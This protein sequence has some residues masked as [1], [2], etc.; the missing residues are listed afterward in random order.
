MGRKSGAAG[1][2][3]LFASTPVSKAVWTMAL[4]TI[5]TQLINIIYNYA[6]TWYVGRTANAAM[7]AALGIC[8]PLF[9][10][11]AAVANL[12]GVGGSSVISRAMGQNN[13]AKARRT[14]ADAFWGGMAAAVVFM[15]VIILFR[16]PIIYLVGGDDADFQY[17]AD[18][19][20]WTMIIGAIPTIGNVLC[21]HLVRAIGASKEAGFGMS[22]GGILNIVLDPLFMF[23]ILPAGMEVTGAAIATLLSNTSAL[24][25]FLIYIRRRQKKEP[26]GIINVRLT[27]AAG[28]SKA[29]D[30]GAVLPEILLTGFPAALQTTFAM[31]S[32]IFAN[33]YIRPYGSGAVAGMGIAKKINMIAFNTCMGMTMGVLPL[34]GFNYGAKNYDRMRKVIRYTGTVVLLFGAACAVVFIT[35][36]PHLVRFFI[37][38]EE[39]VEYGTQFLRIIGYA[40]PLAAVSYLCVTIFQACGR[41]WEAFTLSILRKG[42]FDIPAMYVFRTIL[43]LGAGGVCLATPFAEVLGMIVALALYLRFR[44]GMTDGGVNTDLD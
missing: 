5:I 8:F 24:V 27:K 29:S 35:Q 28:A 42:V 2:R 14:F 32:N 33:V 19:M 26:D 43:G 20:F 12:F 37:N 22:M 23:V 3:E 21:G 9:V 30:T 7:V 6:D 17:V 1:T 41:K 15:L 4:P 10:I 40:A 18:Y 25:Y 39:S 34:I 11:M 13:L 44:R 16:S 36:A 31:V 38:E